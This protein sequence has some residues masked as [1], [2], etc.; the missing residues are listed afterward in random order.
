VRADHACVNADLHA[1]YVKRA[2]SAKRS[3]QRR[4][5]ENGRSRQ[6]FET[7]VGNWLANNAL[8]SALINARDGVLRLHFT[9]KHIICNDYT[10]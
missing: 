5:M 3:A 6:M 7:R 8:I 4:K 10:V 2:V 9:V 1:H